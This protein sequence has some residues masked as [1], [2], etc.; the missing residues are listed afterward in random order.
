MHQNNHKSLLAPS[1]NAPILYLLSV[2]LVV[3]FL[4]GSQ[5][6]ATPFG[7]KFQ[8]VFN[9]ALVFGILWWALVDA[10]INKFR[11][12]TTYKLLLIF[13]A[14]IGLLVYAFKSRKPS[15]AWLLV[16]KYLLFLILCNIV[17]FIGLYFGGLFAT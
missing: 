9:L 4:E 16:G 2:I 12:S 7:S 10:K 14:P 13:L 6:S 3:A 11:L 15:Y 5:F 17:A 1:F 8:V